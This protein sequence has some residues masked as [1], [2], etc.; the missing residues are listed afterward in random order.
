MNWLK[1]V[2]TAFKDVFQWL[3]SP[4]GQAIVQTAEGVAVAAGTAAGVGGIVTAGVNLVNNWLAEVIKTETL[5]AAAG[6][7]DG[8]GTQKAAG[9]IS[10]MLPQLLTFLEAN[11]YST[12]NVNAQATSI[13]NAA[14]ALLN[15]LGTAP[16][17]PVAGA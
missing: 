13:N 14:V 15:A 5:A 2:G 12:A 6:T 1:K 16:T 11:G 3:G 8:T 10:T 4:K 7:Q 9:V 17:T